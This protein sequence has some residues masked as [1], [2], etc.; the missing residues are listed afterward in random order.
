[1]T[2]RPRPEHDGAT[3]HHFS[4]W[5]IALTE[6][7]PCTLYGHPGIAVF[8]RRGHRIPLTVVA[9]GRKA[10]LVI[11]ERRPGT[12]YTDRYRCDIHQLPT[13]S[14]TARIRL[15][16]VDRRFQVAAPWGFP[17]C[18]ADDDSHSVMVGWRG[19]GAPRRVRPYAVSM[20]DHH[21]PRFP[22]TSWGRADLDGDGDRDLVVVGRRW[23]SARVRGRTL[24][25]TLPR[26]PGRRLQ[27]LP[28][29]D[30]DGHAEILIASGDAGWPAYRFG[31]STADVARLDGHRLTVLRPHHPLAFLRGTED[32]FSGVQC[33][34]RGFD[35]TYLAHSP[36]DPQSRLAVTT[37]RIDGER[38][39]AERTVRSTIESA[40]AQAVSRAI[41][42]ATTRCPGLDADGWAAR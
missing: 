39:V 18:G 8:D 30:G 6:D 33:G 12:V 5:R 4:W 28:D 3:G 36:G 26:Q 19:P 14:A 15:P 38:L 21:P 7:G 29:L 17:V 37:Y 24:T 23:L 16:G 35:F 13:R 31:A 34:R 41:S 32:D 11:T 1:M 40:D 2:V 20:F 25:T 22:F 27:G 9:D 42:A 10:P